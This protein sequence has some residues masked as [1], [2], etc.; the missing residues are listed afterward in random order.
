MCLRCPSCSQL[1][2]NWRIRRGLCCAQI[3]LCFLGFLCLLFP[4]F[5]RNNCQYHFA[6]FV[7]YLLIVIASF[8]LLKQWYAYL[9]RMSPFYPPSWCYCFHHQWSMLLS[10]SILLP[11]LIFFIGYY[12]C[13]N[14]CHD[15]YFCHYH[16]LYYFYHL[17]KLFIG[18]ISKWKLM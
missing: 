1:S 8:R 13:Y 9:K 7:Y 15:N 12:W 2:P 16:H 17:L 6:L 14:Y 18:Y 10:S 3:L 11:L 5:L 4:S